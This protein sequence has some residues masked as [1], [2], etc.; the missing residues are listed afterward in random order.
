[1]HRLSEY[2]P[3]QSMSIYSV[4]S[5]DFVGLEDLWIDHVSQILRA[6]IEIALYCQI[7]ELINGTFCISIFE[8]LINDFVNVASQVWKALDSNG[9]KVFLHNAL[10]Q[11]TL[12]N[13]QISFL[14]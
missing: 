11:P 6:A 7:E 8:N 5:F 13:L 12:F 1:M 14:F 9:V 3:N 4:Q 2:E 10:F